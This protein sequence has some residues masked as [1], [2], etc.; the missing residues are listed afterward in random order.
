MNRLA[1]IKLAKDCKPES[2]VI[3]IA[4]DEYKRIVAEAIKQKALIDSRITQL[5]TEKQELNI[6]V[7]KAL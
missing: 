3:E 5:Q 6:A 2:K 1:R 4:E 7:D